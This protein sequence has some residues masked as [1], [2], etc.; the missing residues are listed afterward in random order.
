MTDI[1]AHITERRSIRKYTA[2]PVD[3]DTV[4]MLLEAAMAAPSASNRRPWEFIVVDDPDRLAQ[5]RRGM[6]FGRFEAP[7]AIAVC[8][9]MRRCYPPPAQGFWVEDCSAAT[10]NIL[11][12]ATGLGLGAVW[13][14]VHPLPPMI[15]N[16][17]GVLHLPG[18]IRPLGLVYVGHPAEHKQPRTQYDASRVR[19]QEWGPAADRRRWWPFRRAPGER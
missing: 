16:V 17:R 13:L 15:A 10:Q 5:L 12:A 3:R 8:A 11:L 1:L 6:V 19:W 7:L 18:H 14:G 9:D 4:R 2:E